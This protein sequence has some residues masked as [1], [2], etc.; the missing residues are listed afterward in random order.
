M[1]CER[2]EELILEDAISAEVE[3]H[4]KDCPRCLM[5][6][7]LQRELNDKLRAAYAAPPL[8]SN[9][10]RSLQRRIRSEKT[11]QLRDLLPEAGALAGGLA[12][13][14]LCAWL[15]PEN[16][17]TMVMIGFLLTLTATLAPSLVDWLTEE[18]EIEF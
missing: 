8:S 7:Q 15:R 14:L 1:N 2:V 9:F 17:A 12:A 13:T 3:A 4:V 18:L 5:F 6:V 11:E 16:S 10:S